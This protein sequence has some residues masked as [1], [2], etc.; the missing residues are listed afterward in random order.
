MLF[1]QEEILDGENKIFCDECKKKTKT[2]KNMIIWKEPEI[3]IIQLKRFMITYNGIDKKHALITF[4]F[5]NLS[6]NDCQVPWH[7]SEHNYEL[8]AVS[9][10]IER[11]R[12]KH[13]T[14]Y[15][16]NAITMKWYEYD[17]SNV[18]HIPENK[19]QDQIVTNNAYVLFYKKQYINDDNSS[20]T[21]DDNSDSDT[22]E[23]PD[24]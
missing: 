21:S 18:Y 2:R 4:P 24:M 12:Y 20:D 3:L 10:H 6:L 7:K 9:N 15:C 11:G 13:Y 8:Y 5:N 22:D 17:D 1:S 14:S 19:I 16:K 23:E